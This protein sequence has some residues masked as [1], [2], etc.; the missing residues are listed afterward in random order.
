MRVLKDLNWEKTTIIANLWFA[1]FNQVAS[2]A[3]YSPFVTLMKDQLSFSFG[4]FGLLST[5]FFI[6]YTIMQL[7]SGRASDMGRARALI[8]VGTLLLTIST[9]LLGTIQTLAEAL[10]LR[11]FSGIFAAMIFVPSLRILTRLDPKR[12]NTMIA[13]LGTSVAAG[14][15]YVS[16]IGPELGVLLGWRLGIAAL[17]VPGFVIWV[18]NAKFVHESISSVTAFGN[19]RPKCTSSS[20]PLWTLKRKETW[21]LGY[22]QFVRIGVWLTLSIWLPTFFTSALGYDIVLG[23]VSLTIFSLFAMLSSILGGQ[24]ANK[25]G[26]SSKVSAFSFLGLAVVLWLIASTEAGTLAWGLVGASGIFVFMSFGPLFGILPT[27]YGQDVIGFV[28]GVENMLANLGAVVVPFMFGYL[29]DLTGH[30]TA[31]W[32]LIGLIAALAFATGLPVITIE[33]RGQLASR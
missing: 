26:S 18:A 9:I 23:G 12:V 10:A 29:A 21:L 7:F 3:S 13:L 17:M 8:L 19:L 11:T 6:P 32:L 20:I 25:T 30:F 2:I 16:L 24:L 1:V 5:I 4:E 27:L 28:T 31:S 33:R 15:L 22:Q 14:S